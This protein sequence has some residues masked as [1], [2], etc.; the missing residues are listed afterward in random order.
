MKHL[1]KICDS[2]GSNYGLEFN[3]DKCEY[4]FFSK[5]HK[6]SNSNIFIINDKY[7]QLKNKCY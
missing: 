7:I 2:F 6:I 1:L 5:N 4:L 3:P